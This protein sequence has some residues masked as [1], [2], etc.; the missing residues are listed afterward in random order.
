MME[1]IPRSEYPR[2]QFERNNWMN[3]N[4]KWQFEIDHGNSG[5]ER[6]MQKVDYTMS[7]EITVPFCPESKLSGVE[8][9]DFMEAVWYKRNITLTPEHLKGVVLL[10]FGA[11]DYECCVYVNGQE[12][13]KHKGGYGSFSFDI[14]AFVTEGENQITVY[15]H[16]DVR[17]PLQPRGKQSEIFYSHR[18]DYTRTTGIWQTVWIEFVPTTR[19]ERIK[20]YPDV[21]NNSVTLFVE[22]IGS[23]NLDIVV[24]YEGRVQA[25]A[26]AHLS[27]GQHSFTLPLKE[28]HLWEVGCGRLYDVKLTYEEDIVNSYFGLRNVRLEDGKFLVNGKSVFQRLVLDQ[29]FYP[30]GIYTAP[31]EEA[32]IN[33]IRLSVAMGFN[34]ARLHQKVFEERFLYHC[35]CMG[36]IVWGEYGSWGLDHTRSDALYAM[37]SD[38]MS[39]VERDFNHPAIISWCPFNET[40][41]I[42]HRRQCDDVIHTMYQVTKAMDPTRPCIDS[43]GWYHVETDVYDIHDYDQNPET[44]RKRY[45]ALITGEPLQEPHH[46]DRQRY[47]GQPFCISEYGGIKWSDEEG[48]GYGNAPKTAQEFLERFKGL[49]DA[50]LDNP[51]V[52]GLCYTQLTD[53]E[54]EQ[55]GLYTYDRRAKFNPDTIK[56]FLSRTAA[57][58]KME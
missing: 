20:Y 3:L 45:D 1:Q 8:Y 40:Q 44:F 16:D 47:A 2:P 26:H 11:V 25:E 22:T 52:F 19:V 46:F 33:D 51:K 36:Y 54:Q 56:G 4:G 31:S 6:G 32:L 48:W 5:F 27:T 18:C 12:V 17:S 24:R 28:Q 10:H 29:G 13:G 38:W 30:G 21:E 39:E 42:N 23:G 15:A 57:I 35:D 7:G 58:E 14:T 50:L 55:N 34:G 49:T 37:L 43:S 9:V 41:N 53:V